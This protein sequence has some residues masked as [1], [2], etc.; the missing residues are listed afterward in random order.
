LTTRRLAV[1]AA[2]GPVLF[3]IVVGVVTALEW[4]FLHSLGW[5]ETGPSPLP[6]PSI[7]SLGPFGWLQILNFGQGGLATIALAIGL[8]MSV[9]PR[10]R[11]GIVFLFLGGVSGLTSMFKTDPTSGMP[12]TWHGWLHVLGF[13]LLVISFVGS[14]V[15]FAIGMRQSERW[16]WVG[17]AGLVL[18]VLA[19]LATATG[20]LLPRLPFIY[21][22][23]SLLIPFAWHELLA[24]RLLLLTRSVVS[25]R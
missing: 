21:V 8:W 11:V 20:R 4:D 25:Q 13:V 9:T 15:A 19:I 6:Y 22:G 14:T 24:L 2:I 23:P 12:M 3:W 17:Y 1:F 10:P 16:R 5:R 18:L 7:T